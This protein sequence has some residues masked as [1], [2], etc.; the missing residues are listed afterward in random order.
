M[1]TVRTSN[2]AE[3]KSLNAQFATIAFVGNVKPVS[4]A[5]LNYGGAFYK[6][7]NGNY[8]SIEGTDDI[9]DSEDLW[10]FVRDNEIVFDC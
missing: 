9:Y 8:I 5:I 6:D 10:S 3:L 7:A 1:N 2:I 4:V